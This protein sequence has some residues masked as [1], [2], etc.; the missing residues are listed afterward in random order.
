MQIYFLY[1]SDIGINLFNSMKKIIFYFLFFLISI[2]GFT[3]N[4]HSHIK[5]EDETIGKRVEIFAVNSSNTDYEVFLKI[6]STGFRRIATN[7]ITK[8]VA[9]NSRVKMADLIKISKTESNYSFGIIV[10]EVD[11]DSE[12]EEDAIDFTF[13]E[14]KSKTPV[15]IY[16]KDYCDLCAKTIKLFRDNDVVHTI[17]NIDEDYSYLTNLHQEL[18]ERKK[19][20]VSYVPIL[21][22]KN[23]LYTKLRNEDK[24]IEV[25]KNHY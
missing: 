21:R 22:I 25:L 23:E 3:Q 5:I 6:N 17:L 10:N 15:T 8:I 12:K 24:L 1:L 7:P 4:N 2:Y 11:H 9:A 14:S 20:T 13:D 18:I 19:D 16:I